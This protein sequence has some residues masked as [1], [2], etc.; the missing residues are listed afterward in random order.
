MQSS[1]HLSP[2]K[3]LA[4]GRLTEAECVGNPLRILMLL[5]VQ[6]YTQQQSKQFLQHLGS[7]MVSHGTN[8]WKLGID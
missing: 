8:N 7:R 1:L 2:S 3:A 4:A 6:N 5:R